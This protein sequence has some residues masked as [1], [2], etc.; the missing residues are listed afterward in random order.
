MQTDQ[1]RM[2]THYLF[3]FRGKYV[4]ETAHGMG[5]RR[6]KEARLRSEFCLDLRTLPN[7]QSVRA[8]GRW[9]RAHRHPHERKIRA[10]RVLR[11]FERSSSLHE[12]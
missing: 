4:G 10:E 8:H 6:G 3:A 11:R 9:P 5:H 7:H 2:E 1:K 12:E